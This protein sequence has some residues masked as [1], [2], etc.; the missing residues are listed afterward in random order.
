MSFSVSNRVSGLEY[1]RHSLNSLFAQRAAAFPV[2]IVDSGNSGESQI[3]ES[4]GVTTFYETLPLSN[5]L[6]FETRLAAGS[7]LV[8]VG[9]PVNPNDVSTSPP[10]VVSRIHIF[11]PSSA[12][13]WRDTVIGSPIEVAS[14]IPEPSSL[15]PL[16]IGLAAVFACRRRH[17]P[18]ATKKYVFELRGVIEWGVESEW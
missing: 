13:L 5:V 17:K 10:V 16:G 7:S 14:T 3:A 4:T 11:S 1:I 6:D 9:D 15:F 2:L 18:I 12:E 8:S